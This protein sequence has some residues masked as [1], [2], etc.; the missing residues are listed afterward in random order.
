MDEGKPLDYSDFSIKK[1]SGDDKI[2]TSEEKGDKKNFLLLIWQNA[3]KKT[4]IE[5]LS[6]SIILLMIIIFVVI[7]FFQT[8]SPNSQNLFAPPAE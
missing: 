2:N 3:D 5:L 8:S 4:K 7:H 1:N 6:L